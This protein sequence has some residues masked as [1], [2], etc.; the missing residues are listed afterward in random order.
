MDDDFHLT[1]EKTVKVPMMNQTERFGYLE[2]DD[3]KILQLPYK[4]KNAV[5][6]FLL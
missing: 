5:E 2:K 4:V 3:F 6:T 1:K